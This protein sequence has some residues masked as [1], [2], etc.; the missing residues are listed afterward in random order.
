MQNPELNTPLN[1]LQEEQSKR[2][3]TMGKGRK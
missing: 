3:A 1:V 2:V